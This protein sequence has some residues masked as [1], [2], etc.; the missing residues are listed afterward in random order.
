MI[1]KLFGR[2]PKSPDTSRWWQEAETLATEEAP[3]DIT[4]LRAALAID[5][6]DELEQQLEMIDGLEQLA[7]LRAS[8]SLP[9]VTTQHRVIGADRCHM[10]LPVT[11][12]GETSAPA[13]LFL[14]S[15]RL[16]I[17]TGRARAW[18]WQRVRLVRTGRELSVV[19]SG[20]DVVVRVQ[21]NTY[22]TALCAAAAAERLRTMAVS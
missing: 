15:T 7:A 9:S 3:I 6:P 21:C 2:G 5:A 14:T 13:T 10:I 8:A 18:P 17:A 16:V 4:A 20:F 19:V 22:A 12:S 1:W 11:T